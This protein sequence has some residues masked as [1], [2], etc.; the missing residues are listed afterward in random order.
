[1]FRALIIVNL[2]IWLILA[3]GRSSDQEQHD[4]QEV[5]LRHADAEL[6]LPAVQNFDERRTLKK[7]IEA[8]D[9]SPKTIS[10]LLDQGGRLHK[11][12]DSIGYGIPAATQYTNPD[13]AVNGGATIPQA[14][15]HGLFTSPFTTGTWITCIDPATHSPALLYVA[16]PVVVSPFPV[17]TE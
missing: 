11:F 1:M 4:A 3:Y 17:A 14:D 10:Y 2:F 13:Q 9:Q 6:G 8:R 16:P 12:C 15:P 5:L 7:I